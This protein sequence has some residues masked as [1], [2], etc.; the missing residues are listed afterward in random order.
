MTA[1]KLLIAGAGTMGSG[2]ARLRRKR[3][4]EFVLFDLKKEQ[5][6][7]AMKSISGLLQKK[8]DKG[9][10]TK[11]KRGGYG[12]DSDGRSPGRKSRCL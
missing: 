11:P 10:W 7:K 8:V 12:T 3:S 2:I 1:T 5:T 6:E 9:N 4:G